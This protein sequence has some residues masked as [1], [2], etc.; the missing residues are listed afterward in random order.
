MRHDNNISP[1]TMPSPP[2][3]SLLNL[4]NPY[5]SAVQSPPQSRRGDGESAAS[6]GDTPD[7]P[8]T[9]LLRELTGS[10]DRSPPTSPT[11]TPQR[12]FTESSSEDEGPPR[13]LMF[14]VQELT[15]MSRTPVPLPGPAPGARAR[16]AETP[17]RTGKGKV[18]PSPG[19]FRRRLSDSSSSASD[20]P[21]ERRESINL[22]HAGSVQSSTEPPTPSSAGAVPPQ[23]Y[24]VE[25][26]TPRRKG[27]GRHKYHA[28]EVDD[29]PSVRE[30]SRGLSGR[31]RALWQWVNVVDLD[32]F[33]QDV[34]WYYK[35][36]GLQC[37]IIARS[38]AL[39]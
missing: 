4:L 39:L 29:G 31:N 20:G 19:P 22:P 9:R 7:S 18:K 5:A 30:A 8:S 14:Q 27:R 28:L 21:S 26:P 32:K 38:L 2:H 13:S 24:A 23:G 33:L 35:G 15:P 6:G 37:I 1:F 11:P 16:A 12:P 25:S 10:S 34:Y 17:D 36:K 3:N